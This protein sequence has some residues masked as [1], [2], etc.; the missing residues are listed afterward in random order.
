MPNKA[1]DVGAVSSQFFNELHE[2]DYDLLRRHEF[3]ARAGNPIGG[4]TIAT[5][6]IEDNL[7]RKE[8]ELSEL[9]R[10]IQNNA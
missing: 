5:E 3:I 9:T 1:G 10:K 7:K 6:L 4:E 2:W 8:I